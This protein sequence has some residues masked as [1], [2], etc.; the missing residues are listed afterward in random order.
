[1]TA[2]GRRDGGGYDPAIATRSGKPSRKPSP[3]DRRAPPRPEPEPAPRTLRTGLPILVAV[4]AVLPF[5]P[6]RDAG[7][8]NWDDDVNFTANHAFRGLTADHLEWIRGSFHLGH[9]TPLTWLSFAVEHEV[10]GLD[11]AAWHRTNLAL[12][13]LVAIAFYFAARRLLRIARG[14]DR[15]ADA[16]AAVALAAATGALVFAV[17]PLRCESVCWLTERRDLLSGLFFVLAVD[18]WLAYATS[19][20]GARR[21]GAFAWAVAAAA[22]SLLAKAWGIVLPALLVVLDVWPLRRLG[23]GAGTGPGFRTVPIRLAAEKLPFLALSAVFGVLAW[24]AQAEQGPGLSDLH[25]HSVGDRALQAAWGLVFYPLKTLLPA[26]LMPIHEIR[27]PLLL[28]DPRF[29]AGIAG[30]ALL[31]AAAW[32]ARRRLPAG[33]AAWAAYAVIA[34][35][36]LGLTQAGPQ[37]VADRYSYLS[38]LPFA[39]LAAGGMLLA[40]RQGPRARRAALAGGA[41]AVLVL[42]ALAWS[43]SAIWKDSLSLWTRAIERDPESPVACM[44]LGQLRFDAGRAAAD[45]AL[46]TRLLE[47]ARALFERGRRADP[48]NPGFLVNLGVLNGVFA[49]DRPDDAEKLLAGGIASIRDGIALGEAQGSVRADWPYNL[50]VLLWQAGDR[51][52]AL[53]HF[54]R[55]VEEKPNVLSGRRTLAKALVAL[56]DPGAA[57]VHA[58]YALRIESVDAEVW[59]EAGRTFAAAGQDRAADYSLRR[60]ID[61][62]GAAAGDP[63]LAALAADARRALAGLPPPAPPGR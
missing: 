52:A 28:S 26:G 53:A 61:L 29:A 45:P 58:E 39:L 7:F 21:W 5:L 62:A 44:N 31:T 47:D 22:L 9:Y 8:V 1:M 14:P 57:C 20:P 41:A 60:A 59:L 6:V 27:H 38:C 36:V 4:A 37:L 3:A 19:R 18:A 30:T 13:A 35:P 10:S 23:A 33:S 16:G 25:A 43:Q 49:L 40:L 50:G 12:H 51:E 56:G 32:F 46:R 11:P 42:G 55:F 24:K 17:H 63:R 2:G 15:P 54:R 48:S 34:S